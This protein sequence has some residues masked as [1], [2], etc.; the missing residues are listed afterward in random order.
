MKKQVTVVLEKG[1]CKDCPNHNQNYMDCGD[2]DVAMQ[3]IGLLCC[4]GKKVYKI[5]E[6]EEDD[7]KTG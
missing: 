2:F 3:V 1:S 6:S 5:K 4:K 7:R